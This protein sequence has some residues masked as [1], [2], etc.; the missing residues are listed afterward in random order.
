MPRAHARPWM[1]VRLAGLVS[2]FLLSL[3]LATPTLADNTV[4][5]SVVS[6]SRTA[7]VADYELAPF[8]YSHQDQTKDGLLLMTVD[9]MTGSNAGWNVMVQASDFAYSGTANG[10]AIPAQ[11]FVLVSL[12]A[13]MRLAGQPIAA[14]GGPR[15]PVASSLGSLDT[16]RKVLQADATF[17][18]GLYAQTLGDSLT[19]P[20][21]SAVG[22]YTS[23]LTVTVNTG[24]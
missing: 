1:P 2:A 14:D 7:T 9:D 6:K 24:P 13:P 5:V 10:S 3:A 21:L 8:V 20:A 15:V 4:S 19:V 17:G 22:V 12:S 11:N 16:A 23:T 18:R